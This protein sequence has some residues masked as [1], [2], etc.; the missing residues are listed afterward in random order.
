MVLLQYPLIIIHE[1]GHALFA[2]AF[3]YDSIRIFIGSGK[4]LFHFPF[5]N[6]TWLFNLIPMGGLTY[7]RP[8]APVIRWQWI[9]Y[10]GGGLIADPLTIPLEL[11]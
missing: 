2:R 1:L 5:L 6:F 7:A 3:H 9:L 8:K 4:T 11:A 10:V